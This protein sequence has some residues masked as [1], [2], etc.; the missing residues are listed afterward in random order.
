MGAIGTP[1]LPW[2][3]RFLGNSS[4]TVVRG[5]AEREKSLGERGAEFQAKCDARTEKKEWAKNLAFI[6]VPLA[7][8]PGHKTSRQLRNL[9]PE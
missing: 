9:R 2:F 1:G 7:T 6:K 8:P 4:Q 3:F 5:W